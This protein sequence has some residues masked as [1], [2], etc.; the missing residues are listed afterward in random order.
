MNRWISFLIILLFS[1]SCAV[2]EAGEG[3]VYV[4]ALNEV[5]ANSEDFWVRI[6]AIEFLIDLGLTSDAGR[7]AAEC[8][9]FE[10]V[11]QKRIGYWRV[12]Y[13]LDTTSRRN[14]WLE[15]I[16]S[17]YLDRSGNDRIHAAESLAKLSYPIKSLD[18]E[19]LK[20][21][22]GE[23]GS[24]AAY[25]NWGLALPKTESDSINYEALIQGVEDTGKLNRKIA[26]Y[27]IGFLDVLP[28]VYH[29]RLFQA[30]DSESDSSDA[31]P[32]L[33]HAAYVQR[34]PLEKDK[35]L[36]EKLQSLSSYP[37]KASKI[38][39]CRAL[40]RRNEKE[41]APILKKIFDEESLIVETN[42]VAGLG[43]PDSQDVRIAAA[44]ALEK[45]RKKL[46]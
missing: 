11:P 8:A 34:M 27:A 42:G 41:G 10:D 44:F 9:N 38:E 43:T 7:L 15:Y 28:T 5:G 24:L 18:E 19:V 20:T 31:F 33:L 16:K 13:R 2:K 29:E 30:A 17:A 36:F 1:G 39:L 25:L 40:A 35:I 32:Y 45:L 3:D 26:A 46:N 12:K 22:Q 23:G 14:E 4:E 37:D 6:H 21:D